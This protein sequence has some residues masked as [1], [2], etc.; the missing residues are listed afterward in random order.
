[1]KKVFVF[2]G[3]VFGFFILTISFSPIFGQT[4]A[5]KLICVDLQKNKRYGD[6][7][8][9]SNE[10]SILQNFLIQKQYLKATSTGYFGKNTLDAVKKF[11]KDSR[12]LSSGFV[13]PQ[14]R[15]E[16]KKITCLENIAS[17]SKSKKTFEQLKPADIAQKPFYPPKRR[18]LFY[19]TSPYSF[20]EPSQVFNNSPPQILKVYFLD[21]GQ[22]DSILFMG[23]DSTILIDTGDY[24]RNEVAPFL[25]SLG[26]TKIDLLVGTHPHADHIGQFPQVLNNFAVEN[27]WM[28]GDISTTQT[29]QNAINA[30]ASSSAAYHEP[31]LGETHNFGSLKVDVLNPLNINGHMHEGAIVLK[32]SYGDIKFMMTGDAEKPTELEMIARTNNLNSKIL[33]LGHHGSK[34]STSLE[35]LNAVNPEVAIYSAGL[36]NRYGHPSPEVINRV[37]AKGITLYGTDV[38]G[39]I[40]IST[41]GVTYSVNPSFGTNIGNSTGTSTEPTGEYCITG[42]I[43]INTASHARLQDIIHIGPVRATELI[44]LRPFSSVDDMIRITGI[45][46]ERLADI[47]AQNLA[48]VN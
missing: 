5:H 38:N 27:V 40:M 46:A 47:K 34:T 18:T 32:I 13:G 48:C 9:K 17:D 4:K 24:R 22:A 26:V 36:G 21:V 16:I 11:Q 43:D 19:N 20:S 29:F 31:R 39:T 28:S 14:T 44:S 15:A 42:Q 2:S 41:D 45:G 37:I 12:L 6:F 35:F 10:I 8:L 25:S 33:K 23:P 3:I 1:M 7:D 30:I